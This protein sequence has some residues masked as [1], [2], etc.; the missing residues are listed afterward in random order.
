M[1]MAW[2][3]ALALAAAVAMPAYAQK[4]PAAGE[5]PETMRELRKQLM[6]DK[7]KIVVASLPLTDEEAKGFWPIY[8]D[9][10]KALAQINDRMATMIVAYAKEHNAASLTDEKASALL[11]RYVRIEEDEVKL[12]RQFIPRLAKV[13]PGRKVARYIQI[14]NKIRAI[15]KYEIAG[16]V[17][18]AK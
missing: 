10:Q 3:V 6:S 15:V 8:E 9:Y 11:E 17:P 7:K 1:R 12:K 18:L 4:K 14:E 16:E 13:L 2:I 5:P